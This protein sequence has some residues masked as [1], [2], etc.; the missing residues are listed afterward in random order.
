MESSD[1]E[2]TDQDAGFDDDPE[3]DPGEKLEAAIEQADR[4]FASESFG[5]TAQ[6]GSQGE[7]LDQR[8]AEERPSDSPV[9]GGLVIEDSGEPD[10]EGEM[11]GDA[12]VER[13]PF[14]SPEEAAVHVRDEDQR[15]DN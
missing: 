12:T 15:R 1:S 8:L 10:M 14:I 11:V 5:T 9:D 2:M 13:D 3:D 6:E 4:P 7:S